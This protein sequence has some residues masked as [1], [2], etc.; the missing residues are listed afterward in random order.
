MSATSPAQVS[1]RIF[2]EYDIRG[3]AAEEL[4]A[5]TAAAIGAAYA[6]LL[7]ERNVVG[8]I[9]VGR[10]NRVSSPELQAA[11]V[12]GLLDSG[13]TVVDLG[14]IP[15]PAMYWALERAGVA[16]GIQVTASHNPPEFNGFKLCVGT[17]ALYG[18]DI[19]RILEIIRAGERRRGA[20]SVRQERLIDRYQDDVL[21][22]VAPLASPVTV[23]LDGA[24]GVA[25]GP[26]RRVLQ[27][28]GARV[29][30]LFCESDGRFPNH[31]PDPS[32][33]AN[34][35]LLSAR[36]REGNVA[37]GLAVDGDGDRV[38]LLDENGTMVA[39][40]RVLVI[41][42]R[43][44]LAHHP[45]AS[46]IFDVKCSQALPE[47]IRDAGGVPVM[48]KTGHSLIEAKM[49]EL[50]APLAGELSGHMYIGDGVVRLR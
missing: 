1:P 12:S 2:R 6:V 9:A 23:A 41:L 42:A 38:G 46:I 49:L 8:S 27:E 16:G 34:L 37:F 26:A 22:H 28:M 4:T 18:R 10:D 45:G 43:D 5:A 47:A 24:N 40:D 33:A 14:E 31:L 7:H 35:T 29:D 11:L 50:H 44:V 30:C 17:A 32:V 39:G 19:Q 48:W 3:V 21:A 13:I 36:V 15:T 25:A 20:G